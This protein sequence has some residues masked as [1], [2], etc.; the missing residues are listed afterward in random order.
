M[1]YYKYY[2]PFLEF[3]SDNL[4]LLNIQELPTF[5]DYKNDRI[6]SHCTVHDNHKELSRLSCKEITVSPCPECYY[7]IIGL[8]KRRSIEEFL[9]IYNEKFPD[10][11]Y[12]FSNSTHLTCKDEMTIHCNRC[13]D[14]FHK[15]PDMM[16]GGGV[17]PT[18]YGS[19]GYKRRYEGY[20]YIVESTHRVTGKI[21]YKFGIT[22]RLPIRRLEDYDNRNTG[23]S[24]ELIYQSERLD[25]EYVHQ[26]EVSIKRSVPRKVVTV[27][28]YPCGYSET[29]SSENFRLLQQEVEKHFH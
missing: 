8:R 1:I 5:Q 23:W 29:V 22:N 4:S 24:S 2:L 3:L 25:G 9:E 26:S 12:D 17:C 16:F 15:T 20:F 11:H 19:G 21:I 28:E 14:G 18:C 13:Q 7:E 27:E 6:K 10:H